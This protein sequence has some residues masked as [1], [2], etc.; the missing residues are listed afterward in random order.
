MVTLGALTGSC[1]VNVAD[2]FDGAELFNTL[3]TSVIAMHLL[4]NADWLTG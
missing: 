2:T 4:G 3:R 1:A